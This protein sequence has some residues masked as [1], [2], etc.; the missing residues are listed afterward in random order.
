MAVYDNMHY[1]YDSALKPTLMESYLFRKAMENVQPNLGY[2][3]DAEKIAQ[4]KNNGKFVTFFR[5]TP[6]LPVTAPLYEGVTPDAEKMEETAFSVTTKQYGKHME[7]TDEIDLW[8]VDKKTKAMGE[9]LTDQARLSIDTVGRDQ[10]CAGL[11]VMYPGT[12]TSRAALTKSNILTYAVIKKAVRDLKKKG[13]KP[14]AD[15]YFHAKIDQDT[16]YDLTQDQHWND[17]SKYQDDTRVQKYELGTIYDVKFFAVDNGKQFS[18]ETYLYGTKQYLTATAYDNTTRTMTVSDSISEDE[19]RELAGKLVR[20]RITTATSPS[21]TYGY[22]YMCIERVWAADKKIQF[23]WAVD[24]TTATAW[25]TDLAGTPTLVIVPSGGSANGDEVHATIIYGQKAFGMVSL[26][27]AK[28]P[29]FRI[30]VKPLGSS[31]SDDP[32]EQ[33]GTIGWKV[34]FFACAVLRDDF[35]VRIEHGVSD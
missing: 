15:G 33:R 20:C 10:I 27:D 22:T 1:S 31:G 4:P 17:V 24:S 35:I 18:N 26:G 7:Y 29:N 8:H 9:L 23:R 6:L 19:A 34:P 13:A 3:A 28:K 25:A 16:Y 12:V 5:Y 11:N 30:I 14:F 32:L 2:L 21:T